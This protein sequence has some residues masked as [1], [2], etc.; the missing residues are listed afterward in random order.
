VGDA[1]ERERR[2]PGGQPVDGEMGND[3]MKTGDRP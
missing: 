1:L 2:A 3:Q